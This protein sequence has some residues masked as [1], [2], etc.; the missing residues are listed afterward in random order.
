MVALITESSFKGHL[1]QKSGE[2]ENRHSV[3]FKPAGFTKYPVRLQWQ[4]VVQQ[5]QDLCPM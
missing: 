4:L 1:K 5:V 3:V 2:Y